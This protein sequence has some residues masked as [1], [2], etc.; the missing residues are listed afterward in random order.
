[1]INKNSSLTIKKYYI[2]CVWPAV[3]LNLATLCYVDLDSKS[4]Q[5]PDHSSI[6]TSLQFF[7]LVLPM[8]LKMQ[9]RSVSNL[10]NPSLKLLPP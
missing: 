3:K 10:A 9:L 6:S 7:C 5:F 2:N 8:A 4:I 1:M